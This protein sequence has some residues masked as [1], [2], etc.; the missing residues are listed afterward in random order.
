MT[1]LVLRRIIYLLLREYYGDSYVI[2]RV[3]LLLN[4]I[5][6]DIAEGKCNEAND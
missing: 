6:R 4:Q 3:H 5:A 1:Y 2:E